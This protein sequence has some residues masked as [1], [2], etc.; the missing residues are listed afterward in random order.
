MD[1]L[2]AYRSDSEEETPQAP[3][4]PLPQDAAVPQEDSDSDSDAPPTD[5]VFQLKNMEERAPQAASSTVAVQSVAPSVAERAPDTGELVKAESKSA[6]PS[7]VR[8]TLSGTVEETTMSDFDFRNQQRTFEMLGYA[9]NPSEYAA[10]S[11]ALN[12]YVGDKH[13]AQAM[14]GATMA[15]LRGG[16][17]STRAASRA[18]KKRRK[19]NGDASIVEGEGAYLGP[20]AGWEGEQATPEVK[21]PIGPT[22]EE[23]AAAESSAKQRKQEHAKLERRR[24]MDMARGTEKS[25]FHGTSMYDYQGRTYM[26]IPTDAGTNLRGEPGSQQCFIPQ[27]CIHTWTGHTKAISGVRLFPQSGHLLLSGSMDTKVK[28][29]DVY[30]QGNCL[31]TF[32]G[33][34]KGIRDVQFN[35]SG[36]QFLSS[37][38]DQ[39]VK[40]WDTETGACLQSFPLECVGNCLVYHPRSN[41][42]F[43]TG[44]SDKRILQYDLRTKQITQEY[45]EHQ[46]AVNTVTFTDPDHF[47]STSDDKSMRAWDYDIPVVTKYIA[48]PHMQ[49]MPA[50]SLHPDEKWLAGQ[51]M[52]NQILVFNADTY[53]QSS[54]AFKG[55][56]VTGFAC[57]IGFSPDGRFLSSGDSQGHLVFWDWDKG[58]LV[59][60]LPT[61]K[62]AVACHAWLPHETSKVVTG[63]WDG[64]LKLW[65]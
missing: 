44:T 58:N 61:H 46:G 4:A 2:S 28:L 14:G 59:K 57:Q 62:D 37:G 32:L 36:T 30:H 63:A 34:V 24:A 38:Y 25:I 15:E 7:G 21:G 50:V 43:L 52:D 17:A 31:R 53:K 33:H 20:W 22:P 13:A 40:L 56:S 64:L 39:V 8:Q 16:T 60:R 47:V 1:A 65:T 11:H 12:S 51:S 45:K 42:T 19:A 10:A 18:M 35:N 9:R 27:T 3:A 55:H 29:W 54:R 49:S 23:L 6:L 26:H 41:D 48:D 5:D